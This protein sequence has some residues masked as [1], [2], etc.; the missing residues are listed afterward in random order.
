MKVEVLT[1]DLV[2]RR[3][4][5]EVGSVSRWWEE[6][7]LFGVSEA[8]KPPSSQK[9]APRFENVS[10]QTQAAELLLIIRLNRLRH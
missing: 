10:D 4:Y 8:Q 5:L 2:D 9:P 1:L 3:S 7:G 6:L